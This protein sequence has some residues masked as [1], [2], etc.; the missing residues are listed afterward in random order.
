ML[1][2]ERME[3]RR[4]RQC[5]QRAYRLGANSKTA[6]PRNADRG[7][8]LSRRAAASQGPDRGPRRPGQALCSR[9]ST[10]SPPCKH[11]QPRHPLSSRPSSN[12][13]R[14]SPPPPRALRRGRL[15]YPSVTKCTVAQRGGLTGWTQASRYPRS[16]GDQRARDSTHFARSHPRN[17]RAFNPQVLG[18][19]PSGGTRR[20]HDEHDREQCDAGEYERQ[21][22]V[23]YLTA[24]APAAPTAGAAGVG[25]VRLVAR[26]ICSR[27]RPRAA[28][29]PKPQAAR[30]RRRARGR[31]WTWLTLTR[32]PPLRVVHAHTTSA[33]AL[34]RA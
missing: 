30:S 28:R 8:L 20:H 19:S 32:D 6:P 9:Y 26:A 5:R 33:H 31:L 3:H 27:R 34:Y 25:G 24:E 13:A 18:S 4:A 29:R 10:T 14:R 1:A 11:W 21:R 7:G 23:R 15:I 16:N 22:H 2:I 17:V 12:R